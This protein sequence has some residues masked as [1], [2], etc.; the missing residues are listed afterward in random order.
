MSDRPDNSEGLEQSP[1]DVGRS[2][3][4]VQK[5][6]PADFLGKK[7][8]SSIGQSGHHWDQLSIQVLL[9]PGSMSKGV[10]MEHR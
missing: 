4:G 7:R 3:T 8:Y 5:A 10:S 6:I 2:S 1:Q 9:S